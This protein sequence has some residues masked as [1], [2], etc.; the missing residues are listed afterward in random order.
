[1]K[2]FREA[3]N[4]V[5]LFGRDILSSPGMQKEK[6]YIQHGR[7]SVYAHSFLVASLCV[8]I[9]E[10]LSLRH[11][12]RSLVRGALLHDYFLYDW[13]TPDKSHR[14]HAFSHAGRGLENARRDFRLNR[15]ER[16][17]IRSHMFPLNK[18]VP[19]YRESIILCAADK[20][21]AVAETLRALFPPKSKA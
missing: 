6:E 10:R 15:I 5:R 7:F 12:T 2:K 11:D 18:S 20:L 21:C 14:L 4:K 13:H 3:E 16:N 19:K 1:M 17:M 8:Y 9:A